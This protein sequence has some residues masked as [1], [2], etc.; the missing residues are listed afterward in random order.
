[1]RM[2][3]IGDGRREKALGSGFFPIGLSK[4][5]LLLLRFDTN[6]GLWALPYSGRLPWRVEDAF[7][8]APG[9]AYPTAADDGSVLYSLAPDAPKLGELVWVDREGRVLSSI[10]SEHIDLVLPSLSPDG[11]RVAFSARTRD[12][13]DIWVRDLHS[14]V[15]TRVTTDSADQGWPAWFPSGQRL[16]Y[17]EIGSG[18]LNRIVASHSD[19]SGGRSELTN[20]LSPEVS[21]DGK[22]LVYVVDE[23]GENHLRISEVSQQGEAAA[24]VPFFK[25]TPEPSVH[26][27]AFSPDGRYLAYVEQ[28]PGGALELFLTSVPG[29][30]GRWPV[31]VGAR[32]PVWSASGE[33][34]F[35]GGS[36]DGPKTLMSA[37]IGRG[38]PPRIGTPVKLFEV[39][40][41]IELTPR[42]ISFDAS[43]DG[44]R[45]LM[46][47]SRPTASSRSNARWVLVQNWLTEFQSPR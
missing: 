47:R 34:F 14:Q 16:A 6:P 27:A 42:G 40:P 18:S 32:S 21:P 46:V 36:N 33:L 13:A 41:D 8:V 12:N 1:M 25:R 39:A 10:G 45:F 11:R 35:T 15:E 43:A 20:G 26:G 24:G 29:G 28:A 2:E 22:L 30:E 5:H 23:R 37:T 31:F 19:G 3:A 7:L 9:A 4:G 38:N 44:K 17:S